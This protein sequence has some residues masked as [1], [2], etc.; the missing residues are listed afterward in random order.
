MIF[1]IFNG[2]ECYEVEQIYFEILRVL[3][4]LSFLGF[5]RDLR[6]LRTGLKV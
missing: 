2:D 6:V 5:L 4:A 1:K 3:S